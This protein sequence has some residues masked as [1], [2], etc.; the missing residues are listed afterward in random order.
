MKAM[1]RIFQALAVLAALASA[2]FY[3]SLN[4]EQKDA[5]AQLDFSKRQLSNLAA[6]KEEL[7]TKVEQQAA[8]L[9]EQS[10]ER[11]RHKSEVASL[12]AQL[13]QLQ[14]E[15]LRLLDEKE[16]RQA[17]ERRLQDENARL[18]SELAQTRARSVPQETL[19]EHANTIARLEREILELRQTRAT[20]QAE[21]Q[22]ALAKPPAEP[23]IQGSV[24]TVGKEAS[25]VVLDVGYSDGVRLQNELVVQHAETPIA[26]IQITEVK[27]N[28]SIARVLPESLVKTPQIGDS[29]TSLN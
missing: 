2:L 26:K 28:L 18:K 11:D 20:Q 19:E 4:S 10:S 17:T 8:S 5:S 7:Q 12:T 14:R 29:V 9:E 15:N 25:F 1:N 23:A 13:G 3:W 22:A 27:E 21:S 6:Q 16:A 24:L